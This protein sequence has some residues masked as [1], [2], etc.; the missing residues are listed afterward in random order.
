M[1][2]IGYKNLRNLSNYSYLVILVSLLILYS[3]FQIQSSYSLEN[4]YISDVEITIVNYSECP[5]CMHHYRTYIK[6]YYITFRFNIS[7]TSIDVADLDTGLPAYW[8]LVTRLDIDTL[9]HRDF[10][11]VIFSWTE[12]DT[13]IDLIDVE[14]L[15]TLTE[16]FYNIT[17]LSLDTTIIPSESSHTQPDPELLNF[18]SAAIALV[19]TSILIILYLVGKRSIP[20]ILRKISEFEG[21]LS[22]NIGITRYYLILGLSFLSILTLSYQFFDQIMGG[23]GCTTTNLATVILFKKYDSIDLFGL[24][25]PFSFMGL[26]VMT[27]SI[28]LT[29]LISLI[30]LEINFK[31]PSNKKIQITEKSLSICYYL[32]VALMLGTTVSLSYLLY[33]ELFVI[34]YICIFCTISQIIVTINT[35]LV[36]FWNPLNK[37]EYMRNFLIAKK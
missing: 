20:F 13:V 14:E 1:R 7:F 19:L 24:R 32:L 28:I 29:S 31:F 15:N 35:V 10:P 6:D 30:P 3:S 16:V 17:G 8:D 4:Q 11:W 5:T 21:N 25:I 2:K 22:L 36:I 34:H 18:I 12:N 23:C 33:L 26:G 37:P 27:I 9:A